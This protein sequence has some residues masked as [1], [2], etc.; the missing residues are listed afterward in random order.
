MSWWMYQHTRNDPDP[1]LSQLRFPN[2]IS[3]LASNLTT[4][5]AGQ[6]FWSKQPRPPARAE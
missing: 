1:G 6:A 2:R 3:K 5:R 4:T